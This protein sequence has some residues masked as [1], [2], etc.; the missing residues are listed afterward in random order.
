MSTAIPT[1]E[2]CSAFTM[3][4]RLEYRYEGNP[5]WQLEQSFDIHEINRAQ[6]HLA[7]FRRRYPNRTYRLIALAWEDISNVTE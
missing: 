6:R 1:T 2:P 3:P 5:Q 7:D 4:L